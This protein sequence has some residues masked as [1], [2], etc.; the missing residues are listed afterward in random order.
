MFM[1]VNR[2]HVFYSERVLGSI[3]ILNM[4]NTASIATK[5]RLG[6]GPAIAHFWVAPLFYLVA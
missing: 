5:S 2:E 1:F 4:G 3:A 6:D